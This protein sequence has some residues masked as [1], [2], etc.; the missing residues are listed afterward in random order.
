V[1]TYAK[2]NNY[3]LVLTAEVV[4]YATPNYD[5]TPQVLAAMQAH[6]GAAAAPKPATTTPTPAPTPPAKP[7]K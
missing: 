2:A 1:R 4:I 5:I 7:P 3:D 6:G